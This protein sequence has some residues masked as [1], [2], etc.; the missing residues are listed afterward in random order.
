MIEEANLDFYLTGGTALGRCY[1]GHRYSDDLDL[2]V[3][4]H[5]SF[6]KQ[7]N[8][9]V[10]SLK[11]RWPCDISTT[12]ASFVRIFIEEGAL[13]LKVDFVN[14]VPFHFGEIKS[15]PIFHRVDSWRNVLS[16]KL[17]ALSRL[18]A[19]DVADILFIARHYAFEWEHLMN[20]AREKDLWVDPLE[21]CQLISRFPAEM[22]ENIKW[23]EKVNL[24][25]LKQEIE[26]VHDDIFS[27][28]PNSLAAAHR[29]AHRK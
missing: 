9:A 18:E 15:F 1:L 11:K 17:C 26:I 6:K 4:D 21:I 7:C 27:G 22:L 12:S 14:D 13:E 10:T 24:D 2:F 19:K 3:N 23:I 5:K 16:N 28:A 8:S 29:A 20:E 25:E